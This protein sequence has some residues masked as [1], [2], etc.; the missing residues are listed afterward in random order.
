MMTGFRAAGK[1]LLRFARTRTFLTITGACALVAAPIV[2]AQGRRG[3]GRQQMQLAPNRP[4]DGRY[5][6][7]RIQYP[8]D[9]F[10]GFRGDI[11]WSHDYPRGE[12]HFTKIVQELT[13]VNTRTGYSNILSLDDPELTKYPIAYLCEPGFWRPTDAQVIGLRNYLTKGGFIIFDDFAGPRDWSNLEEVMRKVYP[14][15]TWLPLDPSDIVFDAFYRV[16]SL[17]YVH[18]LQR[19]KSEF[20]GIFEDNDRSKRLLAVANYNND[21][22]EYWEFSDEGFFA[23]GESNEAYKI[24]VNYIIYALTR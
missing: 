5:T 4:Y 2:W 18:P 1:R 8:M 3:G 15:L 6:F 23:I 17:D 16:N 7:V 24:G 12:M 10:G 14:G 22:S 11:K 20:L 13:S 21:L 9:D 19:L